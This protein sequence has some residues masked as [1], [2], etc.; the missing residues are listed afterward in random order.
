[1]TGFFKICLA[2]LFLPLFISSPLEC[3]SHPLHIGKDPVE[4]NSKKGLLS[5]LKVRHRVYPIR[6]EETLTLPEDILKVDLN[7]SG[8][9][10]LTLSNNKKVFHLVKGRFVEHE[11]VLEKLVLKGLA[12]GNGELLYAS[13][14][15]KDDGNVL[16]WLKQTTGDGKENDGQILPEMYLVEVSPQLDL[17]R[18]RR[19]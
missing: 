1:M 12:D 15:K 8:K 7:L 17:V 6:N 4:N 11:I 16:I 18:M 9:A 5:K 2:T 14:R 13:H 10:V 19:L 3:K